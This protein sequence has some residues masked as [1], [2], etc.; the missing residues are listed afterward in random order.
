MLDKPLAK[1]YRLQGNQDLNVCGL[2]IRCDMTYSAGSCVTQPCPSGSCMYH[3][4]QQGQGAPI[5]IY[6]RQRL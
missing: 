4:A 1:C 2:A 6:S 5:H 3:L